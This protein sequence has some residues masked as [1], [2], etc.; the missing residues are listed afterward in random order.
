MRAISDMAARLESLS[1][2]E[3]LL[4]LGAVA[5][6]MLLLWN[7]LVLDPLESRQAAAE[8]QQ[9]TLQGRIATLQAEQSAMI[10]RLGEDPDQQARERIA[11]LDRQLANQEEQIHRRMQRFMRPSDMAGLLRDLLEVDSGLTLQRLETLKPEVIVQGNADADGPLV[12]RHGLLL[13]FHG[14]YSETVRYLQRVERV[15]GMLGWDRVELQVEQHPMSRVRIRVHT[16]STRREAI[17]V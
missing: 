9:Q 7:F 4:M 14:G 13:E 16:L 12:Y 2:R 3:R 8:K 6:V 15:A 5:A 10:R 11:S 1:R 17:G